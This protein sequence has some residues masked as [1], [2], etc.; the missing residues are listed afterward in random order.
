MTVSVLFVCLGNICR[1]PLAE[2]ALRE[3]CA[4]SGV[5]M[6]VDSA[7]TADWHAGRPP[8]DRTVAVAAR[9]G[10][11]A[12]HLRARQVRV[13]DFRDF[14]HII[15]LDN[16]NLSDLQALRPKDASAELSLLLDHVKGRSGQDV[17]DPYYGDD[18]AFD[19]TWQEV[20]AA[21]ENLVARLRQA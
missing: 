18:S 9:N 14:D 16:Q 2:V 15:A 10:V 21:A 13:S 20:M 6:I 11:E 3:V 17:D 19:R 1:S 4:R 8:D 7:G 12:S 5:A